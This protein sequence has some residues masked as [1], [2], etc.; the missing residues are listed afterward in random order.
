MAADN[1]D[2]YNIT[3]AFI[4]ATVQVANSFLINQILSIGADGIR[5]CSSSETGACHVIHEFLDS[6]LAEKTENLQ[7]S[8]GV[9]SPTR[10]EG[11]G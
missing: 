4:L 9:L 8:A 7:N 5:K 11:E 6:R 10:E 1:D 2:A 3:T